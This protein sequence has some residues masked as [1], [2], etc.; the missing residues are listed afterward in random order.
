MQKP[1]RLLSIIQPFMSI[2]LIFCR[3]A[4]FSEEQTKSL[5]K[6]SEIKNRT[7][8]NEYLFAYALFKTD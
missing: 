6:L 8:E 4:G 1:I 2:Y 5:F 3:Y 7:K